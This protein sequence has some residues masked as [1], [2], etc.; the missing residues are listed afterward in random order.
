MTLDPR[1]SRAFSEDSDEAFEKILI[2]REVVFWVKWSERDE[3]IAALCEAVIRT[4]RLSSSRGGSSLMVSYGETSAIRELADDPGDRHVALLT[5]NEALLG[6][7]EVRFLWDSTGADAGAFLP[8][9]VA[10]WREVEALAGERLRFRVLTL[11]ESPNVFTELTP[12]DRPA[13]P[14][15]LE[16]RVMKKPW[17]KIWG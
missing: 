5:L 14:P 8:L 9:S 7:Y 16:A 15:G 11:M 12:R 13:R 1:V 10:D 6:D 17:W 4:G 3:R 2:D